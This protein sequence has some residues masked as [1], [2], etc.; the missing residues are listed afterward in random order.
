[1]RQTKQ[2]KNA[3]NLDHLLDEKKSVKTKIK[4]ISAKFPG[5]ALQTENFGKPQWQ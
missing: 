3:D 2:E 4:I 5:Y 1:V